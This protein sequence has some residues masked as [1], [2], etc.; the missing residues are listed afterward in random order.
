MM[1]LKNPR[2]TALLLDAR[3]T[4]PTAGFALMSVPVFVFSGR[5]STI[6][7]VQVGSMFL[8]CLMAVVG[9]VGF[10]LVPFARRQVY[11]GSLVLML[12]LVISIGGLIMAFAPD[13]MLFL[14]TLVSAA[15]SLVV[16]AYGRM[17]KRPS[18]FRL[19]KREAANQAKPRQRQS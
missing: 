3:F 10:A 1:R 15:F 19:V 9:I 14:A 13:P 16:V 18:G 4:A 2:G 7:V 11:D 8:A 6:H 17:R 12:S 5:L